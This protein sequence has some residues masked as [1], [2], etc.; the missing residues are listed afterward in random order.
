MHFLE[1][2]KTRKFS[3]VSFQKLSSVKVSKLV[4]TTKF[5]GNGHVQ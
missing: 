5:V 1:F 3:K 4:L 2:A